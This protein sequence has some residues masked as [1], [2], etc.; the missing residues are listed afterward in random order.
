MQRQRMTRWTTA[1][2][3]LSMPCGLTPTFTQSRACNGWKCSIK[4]METLKTARFSF[5]VPAK[6]GRSW[7]WSLSPETSSRL[8]PLHR[9]ERTNYHW[10]RCPLISKIL[11]VA[12]NF[13]TCNISV[14]LSLK[15]ISWTV[16]SRHTPLMQFCF[17]WEIWMKRSF[18]S[19]TQPPRTDSRFSQWTQRCLM[20]HCR[21]R[22]QLTSNTETFPS[23][24]SRP[25]LTSLHTLYI[26]NLNPI[27]WES[28]TVS[29]HL[30]LPFTFFLQ[31]AL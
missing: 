16:F 8:F 15:P 2:R 1:W 17:C 23:I 31:Y 9:P 28:E 27:L 13:K 6:S 3:R 14:N 22:R 4:L 20:I 25:N 24:Q 18:A 19:C 7:G 30:F 12:V 10:K 26:F 29:Q 5:M 11:N 21:H